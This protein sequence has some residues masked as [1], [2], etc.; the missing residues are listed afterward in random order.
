MIRLRDSRGSLPLAMLL[1]IV[2]IGAVSLL[3][4]V[5]ASQISTTRYDVNRSA[6]ISAAQSG[7]ETTLAQ[8]RAVPI[9][10]SGDAA[11]ASVPCSAT[12]QGPSLKLSGVVSPGQLAAFAVNIYY[13]TTNPPAGADPETWAK[14]NRLGC[15]G[16]GGPSLVP[17]Y[18][19]IASTGSSGPASRT[20]LATYLFQSRTKPNVPG[21]TIKV[22]NSD[23]CLTAPREVTGSSPMTVGT[24]LVLATCDASDPKQ[25][26]T[27]NPTLQV[28]LKNSEGS[29]FF[30]NGACL[31]AASVDKTPVTFVPCDATQR[32]QIWSLNNRDNFEGTTDGV[33]PNGKC[34]NVDWTALPPKVLINNVIAGNANKVANTQGDGTDGTPCSGISGDYTKYKTF[35]PDPSAGTGAAGEVTKQLVNY[36]QFGR[37]LD[38]TAN[39]WTYAFMV[40]FPCKQAPNKVIQW[41]QV[42]F[43]PAV[44]VGGTSAQ[45]R[46]YVKGNDGVTTYC[47]YSPG[48]IAWGQYVK[49]AACSLSSAIP[50][51]Q[52]WTRTVFTGVSQNSYR[53]ESTYGTSATAPYCL[54]AS[55][56]DYWDQ[57]TA[58]H[59]SKLVLGA[60][61]G[62]N[63][64]KWNASPSILSS[65]VSDYQE[66]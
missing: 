40:I 11:L 58:M 17:M 63:L 54:M 32:T 27:Y 57:F 55:P 49:L 56:T 12:V 10:S 26:F 36:E 37:C 48:S 43:L 4:A 18:A 45:G 23:Q 2:G 25:T 21:G 44:A 7:I 59:I 9:N 52:L 41:N 34:F 60:C 47:L 51:N 13:L 50:A 66:K 20:L 35:F 5:V 29:T 39:T 1:S 30:P 24:Q 16:A 28:Q 3:G 61:S 19:L 14:T 62:S 53:I 46:V 65:V 42:W 6:A 64:Q 8:L 15:G 22:Y 38:V 33:N 31:S